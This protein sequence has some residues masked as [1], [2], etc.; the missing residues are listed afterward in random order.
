MLMSD[1]LALS[2]DS[3]QTA[4]V[5]TEAD[6]VRPGPTIVHVNAPFLAMVERGKDDVLGRSPR[7]LQ[8]PETSRLATMKIAR[9]LRRRE[10]VSE[11][12]VN[13][14]P[15]GTPYLC[16]VEIHPVFA[17]SGR[18]DYFAAFEKE[19]VRRRGRPRAGF[20]G[21]FQPID[22]D[23]FLPSELGFRTAA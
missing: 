3:P 15:D 13:Y 1:V 14:R 23:A 4:L 2:A 17:S 21:R 9:G 19:V 18:L 6:L 8:G 7:L 20:A 11:C 12:L 22:P 5:L 16:A 10:P